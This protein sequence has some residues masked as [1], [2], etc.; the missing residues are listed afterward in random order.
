ML[1][2]YQKNIDE[3]TVDNL[4]SGTLAQEKII[5]VTVAGT[6]IVK[7]GT[8]LKSADGVSYVA[9]TTSAARCVLLL[10]ADASDP[11]EAV[12]PAAFGGEFNQNKIEEAMETTIP[13]LTVADLRAKQIFIAPM[14]PAPEPYI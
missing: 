7:R 5:P 9:D 13:V 11:D 2:L 10:D 14:N 4:V 3:S 6:G 8:L 12:K 1:N